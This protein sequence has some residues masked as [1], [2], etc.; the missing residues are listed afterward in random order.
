MQELDVPLKRDVLKHPCEYSPIVRKRLQ[1][2]CDSDCL[3]QYVFL[4]QQLFLKH[5]GI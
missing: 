4:V 2:L 3:R 1:E 5:P